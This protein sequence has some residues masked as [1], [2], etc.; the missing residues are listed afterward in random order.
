MDI[1][2]ISDYV[3]NVLFKNQIIDSIIVIII[4]IIIYMLI[5]Q[6]ILKARKNSKFKLVIGNKS[7]TYM[8]L[9]ESILK[10]VFIIVTALIV[11]QINDVNVSS[12]LAGIGIL[13]V[14]LGLAI[15]DALKDI[16]KGFNIL[17]DGYFSVGDVIK[18]KNIEGKVLIV[19]LKTTK[20]RDIKNQNIISIANRNIEQV[21][22]VSNQLDIEVPFSY[23]ISNKKATEVLAEITSEIKKSVDVYECNYIGINDFEDSSLDWLIRIQCNPENKYQIKRD[24]QVIIID[25]LEK[26]NI[27]IPYNQIDVH[28][29]K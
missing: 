29:K 27:N 22:V 16:I 17:S 15:Q 3:E 26:N 14:V 4:S 13:S 28:N 18:Y 19:G 8:K 21:E 11:L 6:F 25:V 7:S 20:I 24:S 1:N 9:I 12:L 23:E 5:D 10:Y 2:K